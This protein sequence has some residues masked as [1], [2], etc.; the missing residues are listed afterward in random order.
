LNAEDIVTGYSNDSILFKRWAATW[1]DFIVLTLVVLLSGVFFALSLG[2]LLHGYTIIFPVLCG[3]LYFPLMEGLL[4]FTVGKLAA[5]IR[6]VNKD[7]QPP[8]VLKASLRTL[9]RLIEVNPLLAGGLPAAICV[10]C[11]KKKQRL[12]DMLAQ[13]YVVLAQDVATVPRITNM[14]NAPM[15]NQTPWNAASNSSDRPNSSNA[16]NAPNTSS[17]PN[18]TLSQMDSLD[19]VHRSHPL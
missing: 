9:T 6:V 1:I 5:K 4:G 12:G 13:T 7:C 16:A 10:I 8:G 17:A 19:D 15:M 14:A 18:S 11:T 2:W 3:L